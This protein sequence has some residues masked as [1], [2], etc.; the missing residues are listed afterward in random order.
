MF[1]KHFIIVDD[2]YPDPHSIRHMALNSAL[3]PGQGNYAGVMSADS[4]MTQEHVKIFKRLTNEP[5]TDGGGLSGYFR[6]TTKTDTSTQNI[7]FDPREGQ[8]WAGVVHLSRQED[9]DLNERPGRRCG[10]IF[11]R[12][13][14]TGLD[15][16]PVTLEG[17]HQYGWTGPDD[18]K[19]F[20]DTE[21]MDEN[22]WSETFYIPPKFNRLV[23]FRPWLFHSPGHAFGTTKENCRCVQIIFLVHELSTESNVD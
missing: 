5:V 11:W 6:F 7:H 14:R 4:W 21:G 13:D 19:T 16:I 9:I 23:L 15:S 1:E 3:H 22:L 17:L 20:L 12:H 10:T 8:I 2:F 18:L